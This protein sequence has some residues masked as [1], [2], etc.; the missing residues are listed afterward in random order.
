[1]HVCI[2]F[3]IFFIVIGFVNNTIEK[4]IDKKV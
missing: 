2:V 4:N 3:N 1:M